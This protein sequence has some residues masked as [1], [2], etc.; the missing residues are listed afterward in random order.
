MTANVVILAS[1]PKSGNTWLRLLLANL[2]NPG[3]EPVPINNIDLGRFGTRRQKFDDY[4]GWEGSDLSDRELD[5]FW[6]DVL[7]RQAAESPNTLFLKSHTML[8]R[9]PAGEWIY[10]REIVRAVLHL[11]RH[12]FDVAV[13]FANHCG[14]SLEEAVDAMLMPGYIAAK[15]YDRASTS[16]PQR[17]GSWAEF[18]ASWLKAAQAYPVT[19]LRYED[20][21]LDPNG[22]FAILARAAGLEFSLEKLAQAIDFTRFDRLQAAEMEAGFQERLKHGGKFF[23]AGR[24]GTGR[25][26]LNRVLRARIVEACGEIMEALGYQESGDVL[27]GGKLVSYSHLEANT[28][29]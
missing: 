23:R 24:R 19:S 17:Y 1:Y 7:I 18:N 6:P 12:P 15:Q 28:K 13:S 10:P 29:G 14:T 2:L 11:V 8:Y 26:V 9:N 5:F 25:E 16:L 20:L 3:S 27:D 22:N 4:S 21:L